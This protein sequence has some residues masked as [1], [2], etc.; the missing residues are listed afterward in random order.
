MIFDTYSTQAAQASL[1]S[2]WLKTKVIS[3]NIANVET[4]G[5]KTQQ[6]SFSQVLGQANAAQRNGQGAQGGKPTFR[7]RI[8]TDNSTT[9]RVD[10]NNVSIEKEQAE[11]WKVQAQ[12]SY[13]LD[14]VKGHYS[15]ISRA[16]G[17]MRT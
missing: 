9:V 11:L 15:N 4:P 2:L 1:D 3:N 14:R 6:V 5:F 7:T 12:Y 13:L 16:I 10:G 8:T 17:N